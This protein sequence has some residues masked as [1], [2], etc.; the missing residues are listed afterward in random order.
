MANLLR[1]YADEG[2]G[3]VAIANAWE[4]KAGRQSTIG[5]SYVNEAVQRLAIISRLLEEYST[6]ADVSNQEVS[7]YVAQA[8]TATQLMNISVQYLSTAGRY[9]ASGQAKINE[10]LSAL[11]NKPEMMLQK[12]AAEQRT[13]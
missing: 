11:L 12:A 9:L 13:S 5:N 4:A 7:Y 2:N 8:N 6:E 3:F 1:N 10:M